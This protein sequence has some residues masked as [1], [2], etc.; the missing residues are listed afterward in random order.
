MTIHDSLVR[1]TYDDYVHFPEDGRRHELIAGDHHVTP[2]PNTRHQRLSMKLSGQLDAF[3]REHG[4]GELFAAPFDVVLSPTDVVQPDLVFVASDHLDRLT[5]AHLAGTP[6]LVVEILSESTRGRD[7]VTKRHLYARHG[8]A[9]YWVVDPVTESIK[10]YRPDGEG[11]SR[12]DAEFLRELGHQLDSP[13]LP[14]LSLSLDGL[15][16]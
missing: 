6:D 4:L 11:G 14:G 9:E 2:A 7:E 15:F 5:H 1:L 12:R 16:G 3:I 8:V 13:L 10:I